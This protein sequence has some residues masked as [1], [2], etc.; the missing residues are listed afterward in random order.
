VSAPFFDT[1]IIVDWLKRRPEARAEIARY[2]RHNVSRIVWSEIM[3]AEALEA[4]QALQEALA[5]FEVVEL[6]QRIATA[7]ADICYRTGMSLLN[8]YVLA[9]AQVNG[10]I[11]ITRNTKVFP[12][13]MPGIRVPYTL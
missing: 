6:D 7:A 11:L 12:A 9:T 10:A 4:R 2:A 1:N 8:A 3:A 13:E 5:H